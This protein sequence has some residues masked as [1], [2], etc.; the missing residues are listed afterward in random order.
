MQSL[1]RSMLLRTTERRREVIVLWRRICIITITAWIVALMRIMP[2]VLMLET[3]SEDLL[4]ERTAT[5]L[6][7]SKVLNRARLMIG[8]L[9]TVIPFEP[10]YSVV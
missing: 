6:L 4:L 10:M 2:K 7:R 1:L 8:D 5:Y 3:E 9:W